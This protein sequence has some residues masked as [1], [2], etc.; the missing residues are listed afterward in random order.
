MTQILKKFLYLGTLRT[1]G[2]YEMITVKI[3]K[4]VSEQIV[5]PLEHKYI[6]NLSIKISIFPDDFKLP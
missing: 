5:H 6:Y 3:L 4:Y 1:A 2:G